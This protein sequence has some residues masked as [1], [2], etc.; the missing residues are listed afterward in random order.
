MTAAEADINDSSMRN[1]YLAFRIKMPKLPYIIHISQLA[2]EIFM[3]SLN[4]QL[5][6]EGTAML[7]RIHA[8]D[9]GLYSSRSN[10]ALIW[11]MGKIQY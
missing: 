6:F 9:L 10:M 4:C 2:F 8:S 5:Q 7:V 1:A 3:R 11:D